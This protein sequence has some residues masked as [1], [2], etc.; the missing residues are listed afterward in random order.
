M[1]INID[2]IDRICPENGVFESA[3][4]LDHKNILELGCG[5]ARLTRLIAGTGEGR[6]LIATEVDSVQHQKN[7]YITDLS[8]VEFQLAGSENIPAADNTFDI[9]FMFKSFHHVPLELMDNALEEVR[10][11]LKTGGIVYISEPIFKGDF[12]EVLRLF[13]DEENIRQ[14]AFASIQ[15]AVDNGVLSL[16]DEI[17][18][19]SPLTFESFTQFE[20]TVIG[21]THTEH[22]LSGEIYAQVK[23]KFERYYQSNKGLFLTPNRVDILKKEF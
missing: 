10:R 12:N 22:Q 8:N 4:D 1:K 13:H 9:V 11:V 2:T 20:Q 21:A 7:L 6:S 19:N 18:F 16:V 17:F 14:A 5:D 15:R 3:L 23:Q